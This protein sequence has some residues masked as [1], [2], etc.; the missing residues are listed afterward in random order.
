[1]FL[2]LAGLFVLKA[3]HSNQLDLVGTCST[4]KIKSV[5]RAKSLEFSTAR[6]IFYIHGCKTFLLYKNQIVH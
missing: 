5:I 4:C 6:P 3:F 1:M 2:D